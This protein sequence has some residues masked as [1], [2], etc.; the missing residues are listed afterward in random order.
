[1]NIIGSES[2]QSENHL[3]EIPRSFL[4]RI[5]PDHIYDE[6]PLFIDIM[7]EYINLLYANEELF[8]SFVDLSRYNDINHAPEEYLETVREKIGKFIPNQSAVRNKTLLLK[9]IIEFYKS[10]G[11]YDSIQTFFR[12]LYDDYVELYYPKEDVFKTSDANNIK[13]PVS[14][15]LSKDVIGYNLLGN[16]FSI[17]ENNITIYNTNANVNHIDSIRPLNEFFKSDDFDLTLTLTNTQGIVD[18]LI[19]DIITK[20]FKDKSIFS[21]EATDTRF[22]VRYK[23]VNIHSFNIVEDSSVKFNFKEDEINLYV[24]DVLILSKELV[25]CG[26]YYLKIDA[27][28]TLDGNDSPTISN[29]K[30]SRNDDLEAIR[31]EFTDVIGF[32][33]NN[34]F[35]HDGDY[36]QEFSYVIRTGVNINEWQQLAKLIFHPAGFA[37][38]GEILIFIL[39]DV[40]MPNIQIGLLDEFESL[41]LVWLGEVGVNVELDKV[42]WCLSIEMGTAKYNYNLTSNYIDNNGN[43][44]V[45]L[46]LPRRTNIYPNA[47]DHFDRTKFYNDTPVGHY[48]DVIISD[49]EA[50]RN[51]NYVPTEEPTFEDYVEPEN[52]FPVPNDVVN[53][54]FF[55][56]P[57]SL[58]EDDLSNG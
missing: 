33:S 55:V 17:S 9:N 36:Y 20:D 3:T 30:V 8:N 13:V 52:P 44:R 24:D 11:T 28:E 27:R 54:G 14:Q 40:R 45:H 22:I 35:I 25:T 42:S 23:G 50:I 19:F 6:Y 37:L 49:A 4:R 34:S 57:Q 58:E 29:L 16:D 12:L 15:P 46:E 48:D 51:L 18:R 1:M 21:L 39:V 10:R 5:F 56:S 53:G 2:L 38:F 31:Y 47:N 43:E 7:Y 32:P 41:F 26:R